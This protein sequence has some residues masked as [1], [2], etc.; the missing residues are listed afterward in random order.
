MLI[1][2]CLPLQAASKLELIQ[3]YSTRG[4]YGRYFQF[5]SVVIPTL[6]VAYKAPCMWIFLNYTG[7]VHFWP[8]SLC[9]PSCVQTVVSLSLKLFTEYTF[10]PPP[11]LS[12]K[13]IKLQLCT[14]KGNLHAEYEWTPQFTVYKDKE[15]KKHVMTNKQHT[16]FHISYIEDQA[17]RHKSM[18]ASLIGCQA[19]LYCLSS[20]V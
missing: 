16:K 19:M 12:M 8:R 15:R 5:S 14:Q 6:F 3:M 11:W 10:S 13:K 9:T 2:A 4:V 17:C 20:H 7:I 18:A 1:L